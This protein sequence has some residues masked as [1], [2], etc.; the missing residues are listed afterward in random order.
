MVEAVKEHGQPANYWQEQ[1]LMKA[2]TFNHSLN[3]GLNE[4]ARQ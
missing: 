3:L 1:P 4:W 2:N